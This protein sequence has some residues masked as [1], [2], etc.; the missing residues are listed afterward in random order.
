MYTKPIGIIYRKL[1][2]PECSEKILYGDINSE[3]I[4]KL[5]NLYR[6]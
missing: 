2:V 6:S 5:P 4:K 1:G 3:F